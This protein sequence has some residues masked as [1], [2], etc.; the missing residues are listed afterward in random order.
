MSVWF[1]GSL[2][3]IVQTKFNPMG[4]DLGGDPDFQESFF[5][6]VKDGVHDDVLMRLYDRYIRN[7]LN[8]PLVEFGLAIV[9]GMQAHNRERAMQVQMARSLGINAESGVPAA[10]P[11][12]YHQQQPGSAPAPS[13]ARNK[14]G[15]A[16]PELPMS[17]VKTLMHQQELMSAGGEMNESVDRSAEMFQQFVSTISSEPSGNQQQQQQQTSSSNVHTVNTGASSNSSGAGGG[18]RRRIIDV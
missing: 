4:W 1:A 5:L 17:M 3:G 12:M 16:P 2:Q 8:N 7:A 11:H 9:L 6:Q 18:R 13:T 15:E 10:N 14:P